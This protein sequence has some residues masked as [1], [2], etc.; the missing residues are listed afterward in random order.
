MAEPEGP[1]LC[2]ICGLNFDDEDD[3]QIHLEDCEAEQM[4]DE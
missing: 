4:E 2:P 1:W 3:V